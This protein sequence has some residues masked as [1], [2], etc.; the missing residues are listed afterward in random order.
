MSATSNVRSHK[1]FE[2]KFYSVRN[3]SCPEDTETNRK[4]YFGHAPIASL[5]DLPTDENVRGYLLEAEGKQR[6][7]PTQVHKAIEDTLENTQHNFSVLN[8]GVVIVARNCEVD[9]NKKCL[10][11]TRPSIINGAQTQGVIHDLFKNGTLK[12]DGVPVH[13]KFEVIVTD[14]EEL[15]AEISIARNFQNDVMSLSIAGRLKILDELEKSFQAK[16]PDT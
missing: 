2:F 7:R 10:N 16:L 4:V 8:S 15:I 5:L 3:V 11:L 13:I 9:E 12:K 14:D 1:S 6:R